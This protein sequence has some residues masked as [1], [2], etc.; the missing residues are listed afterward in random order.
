MK[1]LQFVASLGKEGE[2]LQKFYV[3]FCN[4][5]AKCT[6]VAKQG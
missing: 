4:F 2:M 5:L 6:K 1:L 3:H